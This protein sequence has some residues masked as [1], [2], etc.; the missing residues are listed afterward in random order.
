MAEPAT[1]S[2]LPAALTDLTTFRAWTGH[3][4]LQQKFALQNME[5]NQG[6]SSNLHL[7]KHGD[8]M[9]ILPLQA[10]RVI[11]AE[12]TDDWDMDKPYDAQILIEFVSNDLFFYVTSEM[13]TAADLL[14]V[15]SANLDVV[16]HNEMSLRSWI[17]NAFPASFNGTFTKSNGVWFYGFDS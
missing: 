17:T 14:N 7:I 16:Q 6:L 10:L 13:K 9:C 12:M 2:V 11:Y 1:A 3:W 15:I 5:D 4:S 8:K